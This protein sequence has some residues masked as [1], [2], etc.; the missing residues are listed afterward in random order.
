[1]HVAKRARLVLMQ[2]IKA[3]PD[4]RIFQLVDKR[5]PVI[6]RGLDSRAPRPLNVINKRGMDT[7]SF[8]SLFQTHPPSRFVISCLFL[9]PVL[10]FLNNLWGPGTKQEQVSRTGPPGYIGWRNRFLGINCCAPQKFKNTASAFHLV[11]CEL[12]VLNLQS[13]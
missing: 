10:E 8:H 4:G 9:T 11:S 3:M 13:K 12:N 6:C 2:R 7:G 1:M 5:M